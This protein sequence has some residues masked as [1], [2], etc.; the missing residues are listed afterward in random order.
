MP[1]AFHDPNTSSKFFLQI[2][3]DTMELWPKFEF[4]HWPFHFSQ[5]EQH[6]WPIS[7]PWYFIRPTS[8]STRNGDWQTEIARIVFCYPW[9]HV[10]SFKCALT[11]RFQSVREN[12]SQ[13]IQSRTGV[14]AHVAAPHCLWLPTLQFEQ[15]V[16][17]H[18]SQQP[19][20]VSLY[21][22]SR[23]DVRSEQLEWRLAVVRFEILSKE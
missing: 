4:P 10:S 20:V 5:F 9:W 7:F 2:S 17:Y 3:L 8:H 1:P 23:R 21:M 6:Q 18:R 14:S 15:P 13:A 16:S 12:L 22:V 11:S 19:N